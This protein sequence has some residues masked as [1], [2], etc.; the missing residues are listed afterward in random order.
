[1]SDHL[2]IETP[3]QIEIDY[4]VAGIGSRFYAA[5]I[6]IALLLPILLVGSYVYVRAASDLDES[7]GNWLAAIAGIATFA[8]QWGYYMAFEITTNGQSPGKRALGLRVIKAQGYP[9]SFSDSAIRNIVRVVDFLPLFYGVGM[10]TMLMNKNWQRLGDLAAGTLVVKEGAKASPNPAKAPTIQKSAFVYGA[11]IQPEQ[12]IDRELIAIREYISR[13]E[14]LPRLRRLQLARTIGSPI[15]QRMT[16]S[17]MIDYDVFLEE[18]YAL[19]T[20]LDA[21]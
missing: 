2:S 18:V 12:V 9:I 17:D 14:S 8:L 6:D 20:N 15:A 3:E 10:L 1:M 16:S 11:W 13:R 7:L 5:L 21:D 4:S 19:K